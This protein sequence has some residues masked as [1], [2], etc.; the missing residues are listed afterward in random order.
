[1]ERNNFICTNKRVQMAL[2]IFDS[3]TNGEE[4]NEPILFSLSHKLFILPNGEEG[5]LFMFALAMNEYIPALYLLE[6]DHVYDE[7]EN[8]INALKASLCTIE[9]KD[10]S[11]LD[12]NNA[13]ENRIKQRY[14]RNIEA[15]NA[16]VQRY[17][18]RARV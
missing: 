15:K 10:I 11:K 8:I 9:D 13:V 14:L 5:S 17:P 18:E 12:E 1:M 7:R 2:N 4:V 3:I 6:T 16:L